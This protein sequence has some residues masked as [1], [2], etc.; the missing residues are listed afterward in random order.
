MVMLGNE[1]WNRNVLDADR[2]RDG[3]EI[4]LSD[5]LFQMVCCFRFAVSSNSHSLSATIG[6][7]GSF[8][9][10]VSSYDFERGPG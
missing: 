8:W 7:L 9:A 4:T 1:E 10:L 2:D 3:A 6:H 5:R